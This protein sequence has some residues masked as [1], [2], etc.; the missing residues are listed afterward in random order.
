MPGAPDWE[1]AQ[2][3]S[4]VKKNC[5]ILTLLLYLYV[6]KKNQTHINTHSSN[7]FKQSEF[8]FRIAN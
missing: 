3:C 1:Q 8:D 5:E 7:Q 6:E 2:K 4:W